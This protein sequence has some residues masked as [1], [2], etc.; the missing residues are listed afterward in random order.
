MQE[1]IFGLS[2]ILG[3]HY[4]LDIAPITQTVCPLRATWKEVR[5][6]EMIWR[7]WSQPTGRMSTI[8]MCYAFTDCALTAWPKRDLNSRAM[9]WQSPLLSAQLLRRKVR[10]ISFYFYESCIYLYLFIKFSIHNND[11]F[12]ALYILQNSNK[13]PNK[14]DRMIFHEKVVFVS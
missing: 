13:V 8:G 7:R 4:F 3:T 9:S 10:V 2:R 5:N 11:F 1:D 14:Y 12:V 6:K